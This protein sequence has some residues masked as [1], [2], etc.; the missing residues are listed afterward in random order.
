ME[1]NWKLGFV[2]AGV[3]AEVMVAGLLDERVLSP[4]R[5]IAS[6]RR[7]V[8]GAELA[9]T[10]GIQTTTDNV[11]VATQ[12]D[13][14]VL[15]VKPQ[16]LDRVLRELAGKVRPDAL[17]VSIVAG[18]RMGVLSRELSHSKVVRCMPNLP[19]RIRRG[20][21]VW[22]AT[23]N[24]PEADLD[25]VRLLLGVMGEELRVDDE[26]HVDRATAVNGTGPAIVAQFV[27]DLMEAATFIGE[28]RP[29]ARETVLATLV[30]TAEMIRRSD[31]HVAEMIDEVTS[32]GGTTSRGLQVLKQ[33]RFSAVLTEAVEAAY[34]RT[35]E[36]GEILEQKLQNE[37]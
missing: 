25:R 13:V 26:G 17:V 18:A 29:V 31:I 23:D 5:I 12:C 20:M 33:G 15:S 32:P 21:T 9:D 24:T 36:L 10:Y 1:T 14:L 30:G 35:L 7:A 19:C 3:M 4:D 34:I 28:S 2:G 37:E 6:N 16:T 27:K 11:E 8:R 22:A